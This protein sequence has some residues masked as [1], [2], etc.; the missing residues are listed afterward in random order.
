MIFQTDTDAEDTSV[1][2]NVMEKSTTGIY[3]K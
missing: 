2:K 3:K 1:L